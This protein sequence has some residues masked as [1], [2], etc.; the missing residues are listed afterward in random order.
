MNDR[1]K[2]RFDSDPLGR[3]G[4]DRPEHE[5]SEVD[6]SIKAKAPK[7]LAKLVFGETTKT[8]EKSNAETAPAQAN[9][10]KSEIGRK[11][12]EEVGAY[13]A[14]EV[15]A[16]RF[17]FKEVPLVMAESDEDL[18]QEAM[19]DL[20]DEEPMEIK[21][22]KKREAMG[23][24]EDEGV[25]EQPEIGEAKFVESDRVPEGGGVSTT[26]VTPVYDPTQDDDW[27]D[28][29]EMPAIKSFF[30]LAVKLAVIFALI[31]VL[32]LLIFALI[33]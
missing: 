16:D 15:S 27:G 5:E 29:D 28:E 13:E 18:R 7:D 31:L 33:T 32:L 6:D 14:P 1:I 26:P 11:V 12:L 20:A 17:K 9:V 10:D 23:A 19:E 22:S 24:G 4:A 30:G 21:L 3:D 25:Q 2:P 8:L